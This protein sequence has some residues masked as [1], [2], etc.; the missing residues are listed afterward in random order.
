VS[1]IQAVA[2]AAERPRLTLARVIP[3]CTGAGSG[4]TNLAAFDAALRDAGIA[5]FNLLVLSSVIPPASL[6]TSDRQSIDPSRRVG[7]WGDRLYV[8]MAEHRADTPGEEA[9]AG[10]GWVQDESGKGLFVEHD[11]SSEQSVRGEMEAS[12]A[13]LADAREVRFGAPRM[14]IRGAVCR[15]RP[16]CALAAAVFRAESWS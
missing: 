8:V 16:V 6:V 14:R 2:A 11:G 1:A 9:W 10:I 7:E 5:N 15:D 12:L 3:T 13:A 4:P